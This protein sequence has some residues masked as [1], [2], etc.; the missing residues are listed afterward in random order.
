MATS[1]QAGASLSGERFLLVNPQLGTSRGGGPYLRCL[2]RNAAGQVAG[3]AWSF[4]AQRLRALQNAAVVEVDGHVVDWQGAPQVNIESIEAVDVDRDELLALMP[5]TSGD[6]DCM[7]GEV[8]RF[9]LSIERPGLSALAE[10]F[11]DD[12]P[13]MRRFRE[14]PA[15]VRKHHAWIGGLLEHTLQVMRLADQICSLYASTEVALDRD[16]L[17]LG[18]FLHDLGKVSE[19]DWS[20][21]F[22]YTREG[23]LVG[24]L[25][26]GAG[27]IDE[28]VSEAELAGGPPIDPA[29][30]QHLIHLV[31]SHHERPEYGAARPPLTPEAHVL[32]LIDRL[33]ATLHL[34]E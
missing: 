20:R 7:F 34:V 4:D 14:A 25:V 18:A 30:V 15:G 32:C 9:L 16:V 21:G 6:I 2:L 28:K 3:R 24:H 8:R 29:D 19:L 5:V 11:L 1:I 26:I 12:E 17:M 13:L 33:D 27:F 22:T 10:A 31:L 23:D